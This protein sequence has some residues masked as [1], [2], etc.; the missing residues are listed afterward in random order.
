MGR[1]GEVRRMYTADVHN[2]VVND[3][4]VQPYFGHTEGP[5]DVSS[6]LLEPDNYILVASDEDAVAFF[7]FSAPGIYAVHY[8]ML[9]SCR[10]RDAIDAAR[11][12]AQYMFDHGADAI[13]GQ[14]PV[15]NKAAN[16]LNSHLGGVHRGRVNR[17]ADG[18]CNLWWLTPEG[19]R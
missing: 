3:L 4:S 17:E 9:A 1:R 5:V 7:E 13:W 18:L 19:I 11:G 14:T 2:H 16:W 6:L 12:M 15:S 8:A 10:G